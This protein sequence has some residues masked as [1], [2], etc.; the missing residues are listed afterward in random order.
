MTGVC[1]QTG[2]RRLFSSVTATNTSAMADLPRSR[3]SAARVAAPSI[4]PGG[5]LGAAMEGVLA[6]MVVAAPWMYG[7]VHPGFELLLDA[8]LLL[9]LLLWAARMLVERQLTL[10]RCP[11]TLLLGALLLLALWQ[12]TP[13]P[14]AILGLISP[15]TA[16]LYEP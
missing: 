15:E 10:A 14:R 5:W 11:V 3:A 12:I 6:L 2:C 9:L 7:A 16:A 13:L 1:N 8:G 4:A